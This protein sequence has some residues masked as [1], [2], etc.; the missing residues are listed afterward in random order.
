MSLIRETNRNALLMAS[1]VA[2]M[3]AL[4]LAGCGTDEKEYICNLGESQACPC[5]GGGQGV[6][7]CAE[8]KQG[9]M[10][11]MCASADGPR[12]GSG[13]AMSS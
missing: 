3:T 10:E 1:M 6:Q 12:D 8:D 2:V 7:E 4:L 11:C 13:G 9:W 5:I